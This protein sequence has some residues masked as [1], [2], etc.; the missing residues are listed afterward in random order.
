MAAAVPVVSY[1]LDVLRR[2]FPAGLMTVPLGDKEKFAHVIVDLLENSKTWQ[3]LRS[4]CIETAKRFAWDE[5][6]AETL[7]DFI[8][9]R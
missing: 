6:A 9:L 4:G 2:A 3:S 1:D 5:V 8:S 7:K